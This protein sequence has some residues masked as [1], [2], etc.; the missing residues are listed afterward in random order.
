M[1]CCL[2]GHTE[3]DTTEVTKQQQQ[4]QQDFAGDPVVE[5]LPASTEDMGLISGVRRSHVLQDSWA[6]VPQLLKSML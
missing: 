6:Q 5:N 4:Q 2:W 3:S 1:C